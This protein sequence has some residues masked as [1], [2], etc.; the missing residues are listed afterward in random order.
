MGEVVARIG[1][2]DPLGEA[3]RTGLGPGGVRDRDGLRFGEAARRVGLAPAGLV[4][5][6]VSDRPCPLAGGTPSP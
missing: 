4:E 5:G 3:A 6:G 2:F 1:L